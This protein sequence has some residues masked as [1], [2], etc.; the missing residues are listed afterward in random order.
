VIRESNRPAV[1]N[2]TANP[3]SKRQQIIRLLRSKLFTHA[4]I[5]K[6][7]GCEISRVKNLLGH[8]KVLAKA[9][10]SGECG[11]C[12]RC[13]AADYT[14]SAPEVDRQPL[15]PTDPTP[16]ELEAFYRSHASHRER[17]VRDGHANDQPI[18]GIREVSTADLFAALSDFEG[19]PS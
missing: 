12:V 9:C 13:A 18:S 11:D 16:D 3:N 6:E 4:E 17:S 2:T 7:V 1:V 19:I 10:R 5:A 15:Q 14:G 8:A